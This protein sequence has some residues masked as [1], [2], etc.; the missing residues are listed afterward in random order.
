[1]DGG[2][3]LWSTTKSGT[4]TFPVFLEFLIGAE[5]GR[6]F[7]DIDVVLADGEV[8][9]THICITE[10]ALSVASLCTSN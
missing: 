8:R 9:M 4:W 2:N 10:T 1:M 6:E 3:R 7:E 5:M